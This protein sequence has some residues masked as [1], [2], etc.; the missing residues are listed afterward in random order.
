MG[1][2][3]SYMG[4]SEISVGTQ[5]GQY[6]VPTVSATWKRYSAVSGKIKFQPEFHKLPET[7][8]TYME[9]LDRPWGVFVSLCTGM[10]TRVRIRDL[11]AF[12]Y[13]QGLATESSLQ[14][15]GL[16]GNDFIAILEGT[17]NLNAW[18][19]D[20][21]KN[22]ANGE[23]RRELLR[24]Q[25]QELILDTIP[26][27]LCTG[28]DHNK[29][30]NIAW[31][32]KYPTEKMILDHNLHKWIPV[33]TDTSQ[34]CTFVVVFDCCFQAP[35]C[36]CSKQAWKPPTSF[37]LSTKIGFYTKTDRE[38]VPQSTKLVLGKSYW[39]NDEGLGLIAKVTE[40]MNG[41][42]PFSLAIRQSTIIPLRRYL[43][44][45]FMIREETDESWK[46]W[47]CIIGS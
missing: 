25:I 31:A 10:M 47:D 44:P 43:M 8:D 14:R 34:T 21:G 29:N 23:E 7:F 42:R 18:V 11:I 24:V 28:I 16:L 46:T 35:G 40:E 5:A 37:K 38:M 22:V 30:L 36:D 17:E 12:L 41:N 6:I 4:L 32:F 19:A 26:R 15:F 13:R 45:D 27:L 9:L 20:M 1:T 33:L 39:I 2:R 3:E